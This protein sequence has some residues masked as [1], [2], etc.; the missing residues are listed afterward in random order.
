[1]QDLESPLFPL[2]TVLFP[3]GPLALRIFEPRY[4]DMISRCLREGTEFGVVAIQTGQET[5]AAQTYQVGTLARID[6]WYSESDGLLGLVVVGTRRFRIVTSRIQTDGLHVGKIVL[7]E[8]EIPQVVPEQYAYMADLMKS[9]I[10]QLGDQYA[11]IDRK[12]DDATWLGFRFAEILPVKLNDRQTFLESDD[13]LG[14]LASLSPV[15]N[16][17]STDGDQ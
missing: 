5:G 6:D 15:L 16:A 3:G 7:M 12:F 9:I 14:R 11:K 13:A 17:L 8:N 4:L 10:D 1:M 2:N